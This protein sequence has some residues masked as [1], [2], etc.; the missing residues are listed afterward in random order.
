MVFHVGLLSDV[1]TFIQPCRQNMTNPGTKG[2]PDAGRA[3]KI[4]HQLV[5]V[6]AQANALRRQTQQRRR[7]TVGEAQGG[8]TDFNLGQQKNSP[9][10]LKTC[11]KKCLKQRHWSV[12]GAALSFEFELS[13]S[14]WNLFG[15]WWKCDLGCSL[16]SCL[17][18]EI[19]TLQEIN[20][21]WC[22]GCWGFNR[23]DSSC[24]WQPDCRCGSRLKDRDMRH[25][26]HPTSTDVLHPFKS[27][28]SKSLVMPQVGIIFIFLAIGM[29]VVVTIFVGKM[30]KKAWMVKHLLM[31][32]A[33]TSGS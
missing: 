17:R 13:R 29:L 33:M 28:C 27:K 32:F 9:S 15:K 19:D 8:W 5:S 18:S 26:S 3:G 24:G 25:K 2:S 10:I 31:P 23:I 16:D 11:L 20:I 1:R 7:Q 6:G 22:G 12:L 14:T 4:K 21:W 30:L